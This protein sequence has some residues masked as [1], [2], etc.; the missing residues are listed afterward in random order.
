LRRSVRSPSEGDEDKRRKKNID[1]GDEMGIEITAYGMPVEC[2]DHQGNEKPHSVCILTRESLKEGLLHIA[3][4]SMS[5]WLCQIV[6]RVHLST[7]ETGA[8]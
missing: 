8:P 6:A 3:Y 1:I 7:V 4:H 5:N 2:S